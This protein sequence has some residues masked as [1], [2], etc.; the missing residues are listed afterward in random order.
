MRLVL[1]LPDRLPPLLGNLQAINHMA[2]NL[3][4]N[5]IKYTEQGEVRI[6]AGIS[7]DYVRLEVADTGIGI[8]SEEAGHVFD[9]F[10]RGVKAKQTNEGTGLGL[11]IVHEIIERHGGWIELESTPGEGSKFT[12]L[13]PV[14]RESTGSG[15]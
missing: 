15:E 13:L 12:V 3:I 1:E 8:D 6:S 5:A 7:G 2:I 11:S 4:S 10:F 9:E 14:A